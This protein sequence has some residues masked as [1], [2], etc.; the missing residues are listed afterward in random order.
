[1]KNKITRFI[2]LNSV[3]L[4]SFFA[5]CYASEIDSLKRILSSNISDTIRVNILNSLSKSYFN[6]NPDTAVIIASS[7]RSL[8]EKINYQSGLALALKNMGIGFYLQGKYV[9]AIKTWQQALEVYQIIGDKKGVANM[10]GNQGA[11]YFARGDDA[12]ALELHLQSLKIS[13]ETG[14]TLRILTSLTN[15]GGVYL[16]KVATYQKALEYFLRSY[17][18]SLAIN[19]QYSIGTSSVNLGETYYKLGDDSTALIYLNQSV[20]AY[21][22]TENLPYSLNYIGRVY[23]RQKEFG[24]AI[25]THLEAFEISKKLDTKLDMT[26]SLVG[27]AH[28]YSANGDVASSI[29]AYKRS[30]EVG[31]PLNAVTEMKEAYEGLSLAYSKN[32]DYSNAFK[33]QNLLLAIKDTIYNIN[34]DKKL[35]T[36]QFGF[37]LEKKESQINLLNKDKEIQK[38]EIQRQK[39]VRNSFIGGFA[40]VLLF[41]AV[42]FSQRNR[43][44]KEKKRSDELLLNILPEET[45]EELKSTGTAKAKSFELVSVL[46]TDFKNFTQASEL[47]TPEELVAEINYCYSEFDRIVTR[48]GIEKIKTIGD[49]YMCAGGLPVTN[50][51]NPYDVVSAALEMANFIEKNKQERIEKGQPY[52]ELRLGV[53]SGPV[54]AGIVGIKKFAYDIWGDTVNTASRMESS[55]Q[56]GRVNISGTTYELIKD[57]YTCTHRGKIEAKNKGVI[58]MYFVEGLLTS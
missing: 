46:F 54:V 1:M 13:E 21:Q 20:K 24:N 8:A 56:I 47:L 12:K 9:D 29:D 38:R 39:L 26:Q 6:D 35:G 45:A 28:A 30:L 58:D 16:N 19:D 36:L 2:I 10:L 5:N 49:S 55:G 15:T 48:Y 50:Q 53:H 52:F 51:T 34:T 33:Y 37:D 17:K 31:I 11:I 7:S 3:F 4:F 18:L 32:S 25:K 22:G 44:S 14:D 27:L 43:I 40:I 42:F 41:A 23:T 57:K